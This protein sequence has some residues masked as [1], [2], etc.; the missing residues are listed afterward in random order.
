MSRHVND[1]KAVVLFDRAAPKLRATRYRPLP[2]APGV[3]R[4]LTALHIRFR[5]A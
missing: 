2:G 1:A 4:A 3:A 5:Y